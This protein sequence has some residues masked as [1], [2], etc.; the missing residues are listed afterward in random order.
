[1]ALHCLFRV[2]SPAIVLFSWLFDVI[3]CHSSLRENTVVSSFSGYLEVARIPYKKL[4]ISCAGHPNL[5][6]KMFTLALLVPKI[7]IIEK[8]LY[9][10]FWLACTSFSG[11]GISYHCSFHTQI[12]ASYGKQVILFIARPAAANNDHVSFNLKISFTVC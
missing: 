10:H 4:I 12:A 7:H 6:Y 2:L 9:Q 1:M 11:T 8:C 5:P 3:P